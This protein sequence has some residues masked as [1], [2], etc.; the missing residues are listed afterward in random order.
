M[1]GATNLPW[2]LDSAVL[3]R[4]DRRIYV[5]LP[6]GP[7][8]RQMFHKRLAG[9]PNSLEDRDYDEVAKR[10]SGLSGSDIDGIVRD[11]L[12]RP[13]RRLTSASYFRPAVIDGKKVRDTRNDKL[14]SVRASCRAPR[15][16]RAP[17]APAGPRTRPTVCSNRRSRPAISP[18]P[19]GL[20]R[21]PFP[22]RRSSFIVCRVVE[23]LP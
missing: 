9:V 15:P 11:A 7:A 4:F 13:V 17:S 20:P 23:R 12:M 19:S 10:T 2:S 16:T 1:L 6:D 22:A 3:R 18:R 8:R 14:T 21:P 5:P